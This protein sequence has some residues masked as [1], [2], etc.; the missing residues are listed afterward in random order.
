M[1]PKLLL[2]YL[3]LHY[4]NWEKIRLE[5]IKKMQ[6]NKFS[7]VFEYA[8]Q[9]SKFYSELYSSHGIIDMKIQS[10]ED[11]QKVPVINKAILKA[12]GINDI[13]TCKIDS[14]INLHT[15]SGSSGEPL[16][17]YF[18][19]FSDYTA[20]IRVLFA[21]RKTAK[22]NPFKK[23]TL[24]TRN[25]EGDN[26]QIE[27]DISLLKQLQIKLQLFQREILSIYSEPE[28]VVRRISMSKPDILWSTPSVMEIIVDYLTDNRISLDIPYLI[29]MAEQLN[30]RQF[31]KFQKHISKRIIDV[32]GCMESPCLG[33]ELNKSGKRTVYPNS[34]LFEIKNE[35]D[36]DNTQFGKII[37]TNLIN[38]TMPI[39]RYDLG[40][41]CELSSDENVP[42]KYLSPIIGRMNDILE[43]P[44]GKFFLFHQAYAHVRQS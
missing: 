42:R 26:F 29:L 20:H 16:K 21:L 36:F 22:Y 2:Y 9:H 17:L 43:F 4:W 8:K 31:I 11:V 24:V 23:I 37:I 40:D 35:I 34:N 30:Q 44:D 1:I 7:K 6:I 38:L 28:Y 3:S 39:I 5:S 25:E 32:Y 12:Y 41:L 19:K 15:T 10:W 18:D 13:L 33:F 14:N 27:R